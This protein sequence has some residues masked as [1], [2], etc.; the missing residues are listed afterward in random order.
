MSD[1]IM[2]MAAVKE[3]R[4]AGLCVIPPAQDGSKRPQ[5]GKSFSWAKYQNECST[6]KEHDDWYE[7]GS[8][9]G[10][11]AACGKVSGNL[12]ALDFDDLE[13]WHLFL[14]RAEEWGLSSDLVNK[15][16]ASYLEKTPGGAY[17]LLYRCPKIGGSQKLA[18]RPKKPGEMAHEKD[19]TK[20]LA[21]IK[22][23]GAYIIM[24]PSFGSVH[25]TGKPY[26]RINGSF[27]DIPTITPEERDD[28]F[29]LCRSFHVPDASSIKSHTNTAKA[30]T[31]G[32]CRPGDDF[33]QKTTWEDVL[34]KHGWKLIKTVGD[35]C[36]WQKPGG[37]AGAVHA[38]TNYAGSDL[39]YVFST[40]TDFFPE[41]GYSRFAAYALLNHGGD[42][43]AAAKALA[44]EGYGASASSEGSEGKKGKSQA[45]VILELTA[46]LDLFHDQ[47]GDGFFCH[48]G[49]CH[50]LRSSSTKKFLSYL[51]Y[52]NKGKTPSS[53]ALTQALATLEGIAMF[54]RE[55]RKLENRVATHEGG[56]LYDLG[57]YRA[58]YITPKGWGITDAPPKF[59][60]FSHQAIQVTPVAGGDAHK[61]FDFINVGPDHQLLVLITLI[62]YFIP[63]IPHPIFHPWG[64]QGSGKTSLFKAFKRLVDPSCA[65]TLMSISDRSRVIHSLV[66][67]YVP[68]FD[69]LSR[70][71]GET[72]DILCQACTGGGIEQRKLYTDDDSI[73]F[74]ILRCVG[75]NGINLSIAKPDLLDRTLLLHLERI[76]PDKRREDSVLWAEFEVARPL[77]LGAIFDILS[78]A[79]AIHPKVKLKKLPRLADYGR[80]G[81][82]IAEAMKP[83]LGKKFI[84]D[85][86]LNVQQQVD[87]AIQSNTLAITLLSYM[88]K[89]PGKEWKTTIADAYL[90]LRLNA[91][92]DRFDKSFPAA[93][94]D[95]RRHLERLKT[96]L[97]ERGL[98]YAIGERTASGYPIIFRKMEGFGSSAS[99]ASS[100]AGSG[101]AGVP[102]EAKVVICKAADIKSL[103]DEL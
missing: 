41:R 33:I 46:D 82:A 15:L 11:G 35:V 58:V 93:P 47:N 74:Q 20:T 16:M 27:S 34:T 71:D 25:E 13:T 57:D 78:K 4:E 12:E 81:Y 56:F 26:V 42:F 62:S 98:S 48:E 67:H 68:L 3:A 88:E 40:A 22:G 99:S 49:Q 84:A 18:T 103:E 59:R 65:E 10:I 96:T 63:D 1:Q 80:W 31:K 102:S 17:H 97:E 44:A 66:K 94:R 69:N 83:G 92:P 52:Q 50:K 36:Y 21:E 61:L 55:E 73:I 38:T 72:S 37:K 89:K 95:L 100:S 23:E 101:E 14:E 2:L 6:P 91:D 29:T 85:Y 19:K 53:E 76:P 70:L 77:I 79:M 43:S 39:L 30:E 86:E 64:S 60:R 5:P 28:L 9:T 75:V 87:E 54:D 8:R 24:A 51:Y 7:D 45:E 32:A 90:I